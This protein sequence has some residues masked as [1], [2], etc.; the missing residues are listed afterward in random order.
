MD[1]EIV[2]RVDFPAERTAPVAVPDFGSKLGP[3]KHVL[4][5]RME[6]GGP[7]PYAITVRAHAL[8]PESSPASNVTLAV[9]LPKADVLEGDPVD[10]S[11]SVTN[12]EPGAIPMVT[13]VVGLP[14]GLELRSDAMADLVKSGVVD[15]FETRGR[16]VVLY[17]RSMT[18]SASATLVL[19]CVAAIPGAYTGP[20]SR[21]YLYYTDED[22]VWVPGVAIRIHAR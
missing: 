5:L 21:A 7:L 17:W 18:P 22:K 6:G 8:T 9:S 2:G 20:A 19:P 10:V 1:G 3:G 16:E 12:R 4:R 14:G 15:A 11:L 13:A